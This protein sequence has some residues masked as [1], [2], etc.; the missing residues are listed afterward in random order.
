MH[1]MVD[2]PRR[3]RRPIEEIT[4]KQ[5]E[6]LRAVRS[7]LAQQGQPPTIAELAEVLEVTGPTAFASV[8][9]LVRKGFLKQEANTRRGISIA[10]E[11]RDEFVSQAEIPVLGHISAR[12]LNFAEQNVVRRVSVDTYLVRNG[13]FF[14]LKVSGNS[15]TGAGIQDGDTV[16][17]RQQPLAADGDI[18]VA[19]VGGEAT[20]K[21]LSY[22]P[23]RIEL[24]AENPK[25]RPIEIGP[26]QQDDFRIVG[27]VVAHL[28]RHP[29]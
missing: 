6:T 3:G 17:V 29:R 15:M 25:Y 10:K 13:R 28:R 26:N 8:R 23:Q 18:V 1:G 11:L 24:R 12:A 22:S 27:R 16:V 5:R 14:G 19:C 7:L 21:R 4:P 2:K 9:Q 20:V